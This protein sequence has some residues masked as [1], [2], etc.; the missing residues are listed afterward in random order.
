M[1]DS[2]E[3]DVVQGFCFYLIFNMLTLIVLNHFVGY[4]SIETLWSM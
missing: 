1:I 4:Q 3:I 2:F